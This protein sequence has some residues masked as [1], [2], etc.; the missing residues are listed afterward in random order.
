MGLDLS[1]TSGISGIAGSAATPAFGGAESDTGFYF[2][3]NT[4][5]A[6]TN[7]IERVR[8]NSDGHIRF[9]SF[10]GGGGGTFTNAIEWNGGSSSQ[11]AY[12]GR[13]VVAAEDGWGGSFRIYVKNSDGSL[14]NENS[15]TER[16]RFHG[17]GGTFFSGVYSSTTGSGANVHVAS[18]GKLARSTSS[19]K[20]KDKIETMTNESADKI[21]NCRPV[22]YRSKCEDDNPDWSWWGFVAEEVAEIDPRLVNYATEKLDRKSDTDGTMVATK[23]DTP[24]P[25]GVQY[26][27]FVPHLVNI[28]KRQK[29][30]IAALT[31]R[32][33]ALEAA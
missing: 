10:N 3:T 8:L 9:R 25:E 33:T 6:G 27:R 21:L 19:A 28:I 4:L 16:G 15:P 11:S 14:G 17:N 2:G 13:I 18:D 22:W 23:L 29:E 24:I 26:E 31:T 1:G 7:A 32:V 12:Q 30:E 20:Y 5:Y